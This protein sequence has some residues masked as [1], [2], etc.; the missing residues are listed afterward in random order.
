M[1]DL[2]ACKSLVVDLGTAMTK[3]GWAGHGEPD[4]TLPSVVGRGRHKRAMAT[5]GLKD[6]YVGRQAQSLQG[7]LSLR[8]PFRQGCVQHW[9]DLEVLWD[10][11]WE[12]ESVLSN[13]DNISPSDHQVWSYVNIKIL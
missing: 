12:K 13:V 9:D 3:A 1:K 5:L 10:Y 11:I 2:S 7:I 4:I 6:A 8:A